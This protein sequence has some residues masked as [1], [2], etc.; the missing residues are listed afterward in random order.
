[1]LCLLRAPLRCP[2]AV[3]AVG[4]PA[5]TAP[6]IIRGARAGGGTPLVYTEKVWGAVVEWPHT[7]LH[8]TWWQVDVYSFGIVLWELI[9]R[10]GTWLRSGPRAP[11][12]T[13]APPAEPFPGV[14]GTK[15]ADAALMGRRPDIPPSCPANFADLMQVRHCDAARPT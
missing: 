9:A 8:S 6:E 14:D 13:T 11:S 15:V 10:S 12:S 2:I 7:A 5:W 4:T 3:T 1:M